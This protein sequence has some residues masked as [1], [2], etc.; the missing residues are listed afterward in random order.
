MP[1]HER[2]VSRT[3]RSCVLEFEIIAEGDTIKNGTLTL[4]FKNIMF[5]KHNNLSV[6]GINKIVPF[7]PF[8]NGKKVIIKLFTKV[9]PEEDQGNALLPEDVL[10]LF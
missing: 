4:C 5:C 1:T 8:V 6:N 3:L 7:L 9:R 10:R 2:K